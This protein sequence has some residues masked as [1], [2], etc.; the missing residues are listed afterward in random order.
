M[1]SSFVRRLRR[2]GAQHHQLERSHHT[3]WCH[4]LMTCWRQ[5]TW[6]RRK[7]HQ[8]EFLHPPRLH[9]RTNT[10]RGADCMAN[11]VC[12]CC[13][14]CNLLSVFRTRH[15]P[16]V[17]QWNLNNS[18]RNPQR[19]DRSLRKQLSMG[20]EQRR[21]DDICKKSSSCL[22]RK[23]LKPDVHQNDD[24]KTEKSCR[25]CTRKLHLHRQRSSGRTIQSQ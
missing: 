19:P 18:C 25:W 13:C 20:A 9:N 22:Q 5:R 15:V 16:I 23:A 12:R 8:L 11:V 2:I 7:P 1:T 3:T 17:V 24:K 14:P 21:R 10:V 4:M 6:H